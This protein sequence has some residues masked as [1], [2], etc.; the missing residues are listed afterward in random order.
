MIKAIIAEDKP[1]ILRNI[2]SKLEVIDPELKIVGVAGDGEEALM[3]TKE[4]K[5]NI[6]FTDIRMPVM[7]GLQ[8][9]TEAKKL[10]DSIIFVII[11][12]YDEFE[13]ARKAMKLG[14]SEYLLKP[15]AKEILADTVSRIISDLKL[16]KHNY[17]K[18]CIA[19]IIS[20]SKT[21]KQISD[22]YF[23]Y[24]YFYIACINIGPYSDFAISYSNPFN[25]FWSSIDLDFIVKG[26]LQNNGRYWI[27][28]GRNLTE[29]VIV[30][31]QSGQTEINYK[32]AA[33]LVFDSLASLNIQVN[34]IVGKKMRT[35]MDIG[36]EVQFLRAL[37]R[38]NIIFG[39]SNM[40]FS[41]QLSISNS[42]KNNILG[43]LLENKL[44]A[45]ILRNQKKLFFNELQTLFASWEV[46]K[47][48]QY[49]IEKL[50][51]QIDWLCRK[52]LVNQQIPSNDSELEIDEMLSTS[53]NYYILFSNSEFIFSQYFFDNNLDEKSSLKDNI[54]RIENFIRTH[55]SEQISVNYIAD[56]FNLD[57]SYLSRTF[58]S[59]K[60]VSPMELIVSLRMER[61]KELLLS[62]PNLT[63]K[64]VA[65]VVGYSD[66]FYFS[67]IF[68]IITGVSPSI[69]K[70]SV[71]DI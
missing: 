28:D 2:K 24:N 51:K 43:A 58:K 31:A 18:E 25:S 70:K 39:K 30:F 66:Q 57:V 37:M 71:H 3:L 40:F 11:S 62:D 53:E 12:G 23:E 56:M 19:D 67:R 5:P 26:C 50:L 35:V 61:A 32:H 52:S 44:A 47:Y 64:D 38:K 6:V 10:D 21:N 41:E 14:V 48:T 34:M 20:F 65:E 17:E 49:T 63:I 36:F 55:Y 46:N 68:K 7:D 29:Q 9:I 15:V 1:P 16:K 59:L 8:L 42:D 13:Y 22:Y 69:Y 45:F 33:E 4:L 54:N 27:V 60:G